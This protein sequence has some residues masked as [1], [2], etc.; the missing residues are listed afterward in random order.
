ML[1]RGK[2]VFR[3]TAEKLDD[4]NIKKFKGKMDPGQ[5]TPF[6]STAGD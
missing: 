3:E 5:T 6:S 4:R 1:W 2:L